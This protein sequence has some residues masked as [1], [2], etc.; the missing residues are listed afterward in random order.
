MYLC[1]NLGLYDAIIL[2]V[3]SKDVG[4]GISSP[5]QA[6]VEKKFLANLCK[7]AIILTDPGKAIRVAIHEICILFVCIY[8][9]LFTL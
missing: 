7:I 1:D 9:L 5:P 4:A 6:F 2:D 8:I 3:D